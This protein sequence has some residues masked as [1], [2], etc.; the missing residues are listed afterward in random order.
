M[1]LLVVDNDLLDLLQALFGAILSTFEK[2]IDKSFLIN[3]EYIFVL[4]IFLEKTV[5]ITNIVEDHVSELF[6]CLSDPWEL[7]A[8]EEVWNTIFLQEWHKV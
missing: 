5:W 8:D 1:S 3:V 4:L 2:V 7:M 6:S